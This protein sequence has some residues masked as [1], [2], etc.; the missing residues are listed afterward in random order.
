MPGW[1]W[2]VVGLFVG[3]T[4][5]ALALGLVNAKNDSEWRER[6]RMEEWIGRRTGR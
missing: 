3:G 2:L 4:V 1:L 6:L 5:G